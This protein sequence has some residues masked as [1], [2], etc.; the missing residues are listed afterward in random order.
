MDAHIKARTLADYVRSLDGFV[1]VNYTDSNYGHMGATIADAIL[2]AGAKYDAVVRPRIRR[3]RE[4]Y[5]EATTTSAFWRLLGEEGPK[6]VLSWRDDEKPYRVVELT[7]F[8]LGEGIETEEQ[9]REWMESESN[10][11]R[12]LRLSG[13][14]PKTVDYI[15]ILVGLQTTAVDRHVHAL[16]TEAGVETSSYEEA[17]EVVNLAAYLLRIE[18]A[19][20]D[21]SIWQFMSHRGSSKSGRLPSEKKRRAG[22]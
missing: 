2:Q 9:L 21:H 22:A 11:P 12:L 13:V 7:K 10:R 1:L 19:L 14:G 3:I 16:L 20:F 4:L 17:R 8:F 18:S 15:K 5:P 6:T